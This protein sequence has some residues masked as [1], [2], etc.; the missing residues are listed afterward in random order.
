MKNIWQ[1]FFKSP[2]SESAPE[3]REAPKP[4]KPLSD[5]DYEYLFEQL[6]EGIAY[7]WQPG[8]IQRF[9]ETL[10]ERGDKDAWLGW[11][12]R[13]QLKAMTAPT[14]N[15][16]LA[17]YLLKL[18]EQ[19]QALPPTSTARQVGDRAREIAME[20]LSRGTL[21]EIWEY[22]GPDGVENF[23][24]AVEL[25]EDNPPLAPAPMEELPPPEPLPEPIPSQVSPTDWSWE[26]LLTTL[27]QNP[28]FAVQVA[29]E[30]G[31]ET[32]NL[33]SLATALAAQIDSQANPPPLEEPETA[34][35][36]GVERY[37]I[38]DFAGALSDWEKAIELRPSYYQAWNNR[39]LALKQLGRPEESLICYRQALE[40]EPTYYKAWYN[41]GIV[42]E[43]LE[44]FEAAVASYDRALEL[45][46]DYDK[47]WSSRGDALQGAGQWE[48]AIASYEKAL[49]I[50]PDLSGVW[51]QRGLTLK[52]VGNAKE[53]IASYDRALE[54]RADTPE[55]WTARGHAA[56]ELQVYEEAIASFDK[57]LQFKPEAWEAWLGRSHAARLSAAPDLLLTSLSAISDSS[58]SLN[59]RGEAGELAS[60]EAGLECLYPNTH[61]EGWGQLHAAIGRLYSRQAQTNPQEAEELRQKAVGRYHEALTT[62]TEEA[63][64]ELHLEVLQDL[65]QVQ[66]ALEDTAR[67]NK[68]LQRGASLLLRLLDNPQQSEGQQKCRAAELA[69]FNQLGVDLAVQ[70]GELATALE[71]AQQSQVAASSIEGEPSPEAPSWRELRERLAPQTVAVYWHLSPV[72]LT[73]FILDRDR[74]E[75]LVLGQ[76][77]NE[78]KQIVLTP[79][80]RARIREARENP[81]RIGQ[82]LL[83]LLEIEESDPERAPQTSGHSLE[84][85]Q[86]LQQFQTWRLDWQRCLLQAEAEPSVFS[87][88]LER[89][90]EILNVP[91]ILAATAKETASAASVLTLIPG[92]ELDLLPLPALFASARSTAI[93]HCYPSTRT[94]FRPSTQQRPTSLSGLF[95]GQSEVEAEIFQQVSRNWAGARYLDPA[96]TS[97]SAAIAAISEGYQILHVAEPAGTGLTKI[98]KYGIEWAYGES[99]GLEQL[100]TL[101]LSSYYLMVL[102]SNLAKTAA[103]LERLLDRG[104]QYIL[105]RLWPGDRIASDLLIGEFYRRLS[106]GAEPPEALY[107]SQRW[108]QTATAESLMVAYRDRI[109]EASDTRSAEHLETQVRTLEE[110]AAKMKGDSY[111]YA[112]PYYWAGFIAIG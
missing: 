73:T 66:W 95:V 41:Q 13:Y 100:S 81:T 65:I 29:Q 2:T 90:A 69:R 24:A 82:I 94:A 28:A 53:A 32:T 68:S 83:D 84:L 106:A 1:S 99:L 64:P 20:L 103:L 77:G 46:P 102:P 11:L 45:K 49:E 71:L 36:R 8:R 79:A 54:L 76:P 74:A 5:A 72:A 63:F 89:L 35:N 33:Q 27:Q 16:N 30:L 58:P 97:K 111:P 57:A 107:Q 40:L 52:K 56:I 93:P 43:E 19:C 70:S 25:P 51:Y 14:A 17:Q 10:G 91:A 48:M 92:S 23:G 37:E 59:Q 44:R 62:L 38:E 15:E 78:V 3:L 104:V 109:S 18:D 22:T 31:L 105:Y 9:F 55:I 42:L 98:N 7:G 50:E 87:K 80:L 4:N 21:N 12:E 34:F 6:L 86:R 101:P 96:Q 60:L 47:A 67:A 110:N 39:G 112:N 61:P 108:L 85:L 26:E 75:P 88:L